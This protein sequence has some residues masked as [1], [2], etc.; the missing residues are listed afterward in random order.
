MLDRLHPRH[1]QYPRPA[2]P[3]NG[4]NLLFSATFPDEIRKLAGSFMKDRPPSEVARRNS[5]AELVAQR[6]HPVDHDRKR[7]LLAHLVRATTAQVLVFTP[8]KHGANRRRSSSSAKA[9]RPTRSTGN[10]NQN[11]RTRASSASRPRAARAVADRHRR[12]PGS[13][14]SPAARR[15]LRTC[16]TSPRI[17]F[18][19]SAGP[20]APARKANAV[21]LVCHEDRPLAGRH[22][23]IGGR[24]IPQKVDRGL[25]S[26]AGPVHARRRSRPAR[27]PEKRNFQQPRN[28]VSST[29]RA[30]RP[31]PGPV[32]RPL[33]RRHEPVRLPAP[34]AAE[35]DAQLQEARGP[36]AAD[37]EKPAAPGK[38][39][40]SFEPQLG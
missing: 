35:Q 26:R 32:A 39:S 1:P 17:T 2:G 21:S 12:V 40:R 30:T 10:K 18:T 16:R 3:R 20:A 37:G 27:R 31:R 28:P 4:K 34:I 5:P 29:A 15:Q 33:R 11:A 7:E 24:E 9:S 25:L 38:R 14:S 19:A 22:R 36:L 6:G 8:P 23:L 13:T